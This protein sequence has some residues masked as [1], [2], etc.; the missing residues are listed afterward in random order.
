VVEERVALVAVAHELAFLRDGFQTA[1][2]SVVYFIVET[3]LTA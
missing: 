2:Y 1:R 3:F